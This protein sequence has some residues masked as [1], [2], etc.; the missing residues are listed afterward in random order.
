VGTDYQQDYMESCTYNLIPGTSYS[1]SQ[2]SEEL[3]VT[4]K[5]VTTCL[6]T[7]SWRAIYAESDQEFDF[8]VSEMIELCNDY[9]YADIVAWS[10]N[11]AAVRFALQ[12]ELMNTEG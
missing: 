8:H 6:R 2:R 10:E 5:Q 9:G 3:E 1:E 11:E 4:W 7:Y 12:Q